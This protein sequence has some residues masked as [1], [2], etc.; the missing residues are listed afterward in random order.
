MVNM[1]SSQRYEGMR[2]A[3]IR[4]LGARSYDSD[5]GPHSSTHRV[6]ATEDCC[7]GS[8]GNEDK[9]LEA[10]VKLSTIGQLSPNDHLVLHECPEKGLWG[11]GVE[12]KSTEALP[13]HR[14][15]ERPRS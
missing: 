5:T 8:E 15:S 13:S 14:L 6:A 2:R 3:V 1:R 4:I 10:T 12:E 11:N 7:E 9:V